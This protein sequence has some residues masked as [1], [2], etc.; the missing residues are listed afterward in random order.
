MTHG[1]VIHPMPGREHEVGLLVEAIMLIAEAAGRVGQE[2]LVLSADLDEI[3]EHGKAARAID[4]SGEL[5]DAVKAVTKKMV[6]SAH[7]A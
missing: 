5:L 7:N 6:E 3:M 4:L 2:L 1:V